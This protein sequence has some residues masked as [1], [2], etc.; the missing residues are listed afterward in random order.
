MNKFIMSA[1]VLSIML[2][3]GCA[4]KNDSTKLNGLGL[5][6]QSNVSKLSDGR[7]F[8]EVEAAPAAGRLPGAMAQA[9]QNAVN[10][11]KLKNQTMKEIKTETESHLLVNGVAK[12]TFECI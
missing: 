7:Y 10:Y 8:T 1:S 3:S 9:T 12:L 5:T 6:Y 11:C 2:L 4:V